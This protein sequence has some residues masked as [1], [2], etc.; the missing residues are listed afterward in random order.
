MRCR[1]DKKPV[2]NANDFFRIFIYSHPVVRLRFTA[3]DAA[4]A[5][6]A[7]L[8]WDANSEE[9]LA[10]YEI[11][12]KLDVDGEPCNGTGA[13]EGSSPVTVHLADLDNPAS[14]SSL[15]VDGVGCGE[16]IFL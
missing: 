13:N 14:P 6:G 1:N 2:Q 4:H 3:A 16:N 11:Y 15:F 5:A 8:T 10:G 7:Y 9:N 12:Y